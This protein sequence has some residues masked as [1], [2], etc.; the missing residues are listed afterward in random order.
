MPFGCC[1]SCDCQFTASF[2]DRFNRT[3]GCACHFDRCFRC[4]FALGENA[5][6]VELAADQAGLNECVFVDF[7]SVQFLLIDEFLDQAE[8]YNGEFLAVRLV[9]AALW[10]ALVEWHLAAL[11]ATNGHTGTGFLTFDTT[12]THFTHA[13]TRATANAFAWF[14]CTWIVVKFV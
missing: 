9:E 4:D 11:V 2:F 12:A 14:R 10:Q 1:R 13:G 8:V 7:L 5:D 6:T 3:F